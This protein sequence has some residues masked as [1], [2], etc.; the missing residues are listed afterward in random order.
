MNN[1]APYTG[2]TT[3]EAALRMVR[4]LWA[5]MLTAPLIAAGFFSQ[6]SLKNTPGAQFVQ[7]AP[8]ILIALAA[9]EL[10]AMYFVRGKIFGKYRDAQGVVSPQGFVTGNLIVFAGCEGLALATVVFCLVTKTV[11]PTAVPGLIALAVLAS[12]FP[13]GRVMYPSQGEPNPYRPDNL[14]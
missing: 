7:I 4:L 9:I 2:P 11:F 13:N 10:P 5:V 14:K 1:N 12:N 6:I 3:P 8:W